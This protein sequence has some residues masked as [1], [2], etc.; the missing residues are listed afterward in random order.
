MCGAVGRSGLPMPRSITS[1]PAARARA[2]MAFTSANTYGGRRFSRWNSE[3]SISV[4][5]GRLGRALKY[6]GASR[7]LAPLV[8]G[9]RRR[10]RRRNGGGRYR[11]RRRH[12][13]LRRFLGIPGLLGR[14]LRLALGRFL[15]GLLARFAVLLVALSGFL[16]G[17]LELSLLAALGGNDRA[18]LRAAGLVDRRDA[19][20]VLAARARRR[21][22]T[23][24]CD[25][26]LGTGTHPRGIGRAAAEPVAAGQQRK[27][28]YADQAIEVK[29]ADPVSLSAHRHCYPL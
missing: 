12:R 29:P 25:L 4:F 20:I 23:A 16:G 13:R 11:G 3:S 8:C 17:R 1:W 9:W 7:K 10:W 21:Q 5:L 15:G 6:V 18:D 28:R 22:Q 19:G 2:F 24:G 14:F 26:A 27:R